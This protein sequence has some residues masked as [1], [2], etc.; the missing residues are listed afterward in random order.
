MDKKVA[1][2]L[3]QIKALDASAL[4]VLGIALK[5]N[6]IKISSRAIKEPTVY[7]AARYNLVDSSPTARRVRNAGTIEYLTQKQLDNT[8]D[9]WLR[10]KKNEAKL[11]IV[12]DL[13]S[14]GV[15]GKDGSFPKETFTNFE[16][17]AITHTDDVST[18]PTTFD[19]A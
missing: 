15:V 1:A 11:P 16:L 2:I 8:L 13:L 17:V 7:V 14:R 19:V 4:N 6:N 5:E 9:T 3:T 18:L 10:G 12:K